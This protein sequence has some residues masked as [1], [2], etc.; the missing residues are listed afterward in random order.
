MKKGYFLQNIV[1][2]I[3]FGILGTIISFIVLGTFINI[4]YNNKLINSD[5][6]NIF[7]KII[8]FKKIT[9]FFSKF[10]SNVLAIGSHI[11]L[12]KKK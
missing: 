8:S 10:I 2:S 11:Y 1:S 12:T 6:K 4:I 7:T 3:L 5:R 9:V